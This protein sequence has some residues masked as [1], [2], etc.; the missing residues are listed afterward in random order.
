MTV[1]NANKVASN[2]AVLLVFSPPPPTTPVVTAVSSLKA[3]NTAQTLTIAGTGFT[4]GN[5]LKVIVGYNSY[6]YYYPV[7]TATATQ[8]Q[9]QIDP[10]TV[11]RT[12]EVEVID[13]NV[14]ISNVAALQSQ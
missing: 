1:V 3:A 6:G 14:A 9:V 12:W 2:S 5:G 4:P 11:A 10:G 8:I 7:I 13:S